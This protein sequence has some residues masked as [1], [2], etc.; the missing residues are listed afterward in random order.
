MYLFSF[1]LQG[2]AALC[3]RRGFSTGSVVHSCTSISSCWSW[4]GILNFGNSLPPQ[5]S[6]RLLFRGRRGPFASQ[7]RIFNPST[8]DLLITWHFLFAGMQTKDHPSEIHNCRHNFWKG[9][10]SLMVSPGPFS[11]GPF[12][13]RPSGQM[14]SRPASYTFKWGIGGLVAGRMNRRAMILCKS[15]TRS[16]KP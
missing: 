2:L 14:D 10:A 11:I 15:E 9:R 16:F 8:W 6:P 12:V 1:W 7:S 13:A 4:R 5:L 3:W